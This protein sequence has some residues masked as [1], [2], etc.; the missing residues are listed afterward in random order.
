MLLEQCRDQIT[1]F[2]NARNKLSAITLEDLK[3]PKELICNVSIRII[4]RK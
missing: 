2:D 3:V 4:I 1:E